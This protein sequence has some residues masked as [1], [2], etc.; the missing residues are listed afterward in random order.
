MI[1]IK[2]DLNSQNND[3]LDGDLPLPDTE[4][5]TR[6]YK[7]CQVNVDMT[8]PLRLY[9]VVHDNDDGENLDLFVW[10]EALD[11]VIDHWRSYYELDDD[12]QPERIFE[13]SMAAPRPGPVE[14]NVSGQAC[15]VFGDK[16]GPR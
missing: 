15:C 11:A 2:D 8:P 14:W 7:G 5:N 16:R 4:A 12:E 6:S 9:F 1:E 3:K 10:S 13:I